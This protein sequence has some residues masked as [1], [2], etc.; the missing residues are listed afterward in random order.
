M[1]LLAMTDTLDAILFDLGSVLLRYDPRRVF[2]AIEAFGPAVSPWEVFGD[3]HRWELQ[4]R[5][6][7]G[8]LASAAKCAELNRLFGLERPEADWAAAWASGCTEPEP[9]MPEL[10]AELAPRIAIGC[11]SNTVPWHWAAGLELVP[12]LAAMP[13]H[14]LSYELGCRKPGERIYRLSLEAL[15]LPGER[16]AFIDDRPENVAGAEALGIRAI[17]FE[18]AAQVRGALRGLGMSV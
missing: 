1:L 17:L 14:L 7:I 12:G 10:V 11:L 18:D 16:V 9:G 13:H 3:P 5:A 6:E 2:A 4:E 15:G 8:A